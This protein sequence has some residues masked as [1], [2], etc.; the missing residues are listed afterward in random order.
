VHWRTIGNMATSTHRSRTA[1]CTASI[2]VIEPASSGVGSV[3]SPLHAHPRKSEQ[4]MAAGYR[5]AK[6]ALAHADERASA[7][8][9]GRRGRG[10]GRCRKV[11]PSAA[12]P[13]RSIGRWRR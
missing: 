10:R 7:R 3:R 1:R 12:I 5:D 6:R 9:P 13:G 11:L 8:P 4:L 2:T